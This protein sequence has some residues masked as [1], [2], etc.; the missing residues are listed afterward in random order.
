MPLQNWTSTLQNLF[1]LL[2][3]KMEKI[4][5]PQVYDVSLPALKGNWRKI[6]ILWVSYMKNNLNW[7]GKVFSQNKESL[8]LMLYVPKNGKESESRVWKWLNLKSFLLH[9]MLVIEYCI[10]CQKDVIKSFMSLL[11]ETGHAY[12]KHNTVWK[13]C[14]HG[15]YAFVKLY[16]KSHS[17]AA[18]THSIS[19]T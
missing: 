3:V 7:R 15:I 17:F 18:L 11:L 8:T 4:I 16:Q 1:A 10:S 5:N 2:Q 9:S 12:N 19:D 6:T 13:V 14:L